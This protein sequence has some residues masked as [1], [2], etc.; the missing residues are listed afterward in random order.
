MWGRLTLGIPQ[1]QNVKDIPRTASHAVVPNLVPALAH[2]ECCAGRS[3]DPGSFDERLRRRGED[4]QLG[5]VVAESGGNV[6]RG[7]LRDSYGLSMLRL[8][9]SCFISVWPSVSACRYIHIY[10]RQLLRSLPKT[11]LPLSLRVSFLDDAHFASVH[12]TRC[13][14][15]SS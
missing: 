4:Q 10:H 3:C 14:K 7:W 1:P 5:R 9:N 8:L 13:K 15:T 6:H 12:G 11:T 2:L